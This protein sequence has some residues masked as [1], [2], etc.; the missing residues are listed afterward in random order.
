VVR[1]GFRLVPSV[2]KTGSGQWGRYDFSTA[3]GAATVAA[4]ALVWQPVTLPALLGWAVPLCYLSFFLTTMVAAVA[5]AC[6]DLTRVARTSEYFWVPT[7]C[8]SM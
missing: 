7:R 8:A 5:V 2:V 3:C 6:T 1:H 4:H